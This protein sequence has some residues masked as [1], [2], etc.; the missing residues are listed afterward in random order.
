[1]DRE[2]CFV[3]SR[4]AGGCYGNG[5]DRLRGRALALAQHGAEVILAGRSERK[6]RDAIRKI[7]ALAPEARVRFELLDLADLSSVTAF[8]NQFG[9]SGSSARSPN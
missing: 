2:R 8:S 6:G 5:R 7:L 9:G 1:M 4:Q 3:A